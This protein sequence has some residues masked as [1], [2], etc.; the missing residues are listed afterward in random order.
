MSYLRTIIRAFAPVNS[1]ETE[2]E[3][4]AR[5]EYP[6]DSEY[7]LGFIIKHNRGPVKGRDY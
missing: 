5:I 1:H 4:W 6:H 7:A 2:L 3:R